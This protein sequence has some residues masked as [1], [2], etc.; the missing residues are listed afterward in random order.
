VIITYI[1]I[2]VSRLDFG[3]L[4]AW[5]CVHTQ[6]CLVLFFMAK[7]TETSPCLEGWKLGIVIAALF[8]GSFLIALD[9]S[10]L[11][12]A[13]PRIST[14]FQAFDDVLW[15]GAAYLLTVTAFQPVFGSLYKFFDTTIVYRVSIL[16]FEGMLQV[17]VEDRN[18]DCVK[19]DP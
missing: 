19:L 14:D 13:I 7:T 2:V 4:I 6:T 15:Y 10:I 3:N 16:V 11:N 18:A 9:T 1:I 17:D 12:V 5:T 8:W